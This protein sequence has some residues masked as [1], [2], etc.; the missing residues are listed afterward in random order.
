M[1]KDE[2]L[3]R[4]R[5]GKPVEV[6]HAIANDP[7]A[8][9]DFIL[10]LGPHLIAPLLAVDRRKRGLGG[11]DSSGIS[12]APRPDWGRFDW[13]RY[14]N[15]LRR[16]AHGV[17]KTADWANRVVKAFGKQEKLAYGAL[18]ARL[19]EEDAAILDRVCRRSLAA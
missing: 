14:R 15:Y 19:T 7:T 9:K 2:L 16:A 4:L 3:S 10:T 6:L 17:R 1:T 12:E 11:Y 5:N 13:Q 18:R 8:A